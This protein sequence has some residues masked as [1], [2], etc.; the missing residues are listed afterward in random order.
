MVPPLILQPL[1]EN[2]IVHGLGGSRGGGGDGVSV[3]ARRGTD[4]TSLSVSPTTAREGRRR[5]WREPH[6]IPLR[7]RL[8]LAYGG[9]AELRSARDEDA[10][11]GQPGYLVEMLG[12]SGDRADEGGLGRDC[13][14]RGRE[15]GGAW[16]ACW[17]AAVDDVEVVGQAGDGEEALARIERTSTRRGAPRHPHARAFRRAR[18]RRAGLTRPVAVIF[19]TAFDQ[20][21]IPAFDAA[22][23]DYLLKPFSR[24]RFLAAVERARVWIAAAQGAPVGERL[25]EV[26]EPGYLTRLFVRERGAV[27]PVR[28]SP[29]CNTWNRTTTT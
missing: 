13:R 12:A 16:C 15:R 1:V 7:E 23:V 8:R 21:A 28:A 9:A 10:I 20:Y 14:R 24:D 18:G 4:R 26:T 25:R 19:T 6:S 29:P 5:G 11:E 2:A 3:V 27:R 22:A 17:R